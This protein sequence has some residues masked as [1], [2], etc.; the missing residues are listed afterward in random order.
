MN[1]RKMYVDYYRNNQHIIPEED[2]A[3]WQA[4]EDRFKVDLQAEQLEPAE[5]EEDLPF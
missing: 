5:A 2:R 3:A 1:T 4:Y